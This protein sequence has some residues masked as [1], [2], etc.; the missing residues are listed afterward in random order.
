MLTVTD[1]A[2][3]HLAHMLDNA[4]APGG[5]VIRYVSKSGG[6]RLTL[7]TPVLSDETIDHEGRPVL[8]FDTRVSRLLSKKTLDIEQTE[9]G[10]S[11]KLE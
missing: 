11:L 2:R 8:V 7:D 9:G 6:I 3:A 10:T 1:A 5:S 4:D